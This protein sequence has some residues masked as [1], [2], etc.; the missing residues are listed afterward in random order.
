MGSPFINLFKYPCIWQNQEKFLKKTPQ[1]PRKKYCHFDAFKIVLS[2]IMNGDPQ[3]LFH[4]FKI[5]Y[6]RLCAKNI[7]NF[8]PAVFPEKTWKIFTK[9]WFWGNYPLIFTLSGQRQD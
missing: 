9:N 3:L 8:Y 5:K 4:I 7:I 6:L 1:N 2:K